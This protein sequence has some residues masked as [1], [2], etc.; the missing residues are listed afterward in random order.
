VLLLGLAEA[1]IDSRTTGR[2]LFCDRTASHP[3]AVEHTHPGG[4][5]WPQEWES[6]EE[7]ETWIAFR[8]EN[9][10]YSRHGCASTCIEW[11]FWN[12]NLVLI[13]ETAMECLT[14]PFG[15]AADPEL[16]RIVD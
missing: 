14:A 7:R 4:R 10:G 12:A 15:P 8:G 6:A 9:Q 13:A 11:V 5:S 1:G 3:A 16:A 2:T